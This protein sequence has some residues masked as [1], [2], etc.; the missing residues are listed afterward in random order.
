MHDYSIDKHP[1]EAIIFWLSCGAMIITP[2]LNSIIQTL[3]SIGNWSVPLSGISAF[4]IFRIILWWFDKYLWKSE[5]FRKAFM[6]PDLNGVWACEGET[7]KKN[8]SDMP[9]PWEATITITQSW[10]KILVHLKTNK[11]GSEST[12]A[13]ITRIEGAGYKLLYSYAN[14]PKKIESGLTRHDGLAE[15]AFNSECNEADG[16][17]FTDEHRSTAGTMKIRKIENE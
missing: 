7:I 11:S 4:L 14:D 6:V 10:S 16:C 5:L 9:K 8:G 13:S 17:Y 2:L 1:R 12:S 3:S 15:I